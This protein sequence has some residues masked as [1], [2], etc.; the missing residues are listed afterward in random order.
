MMNGLKVSF[1]YEWSHCSESLHLVKCMN[2]FM[3]EHCLQSVQIGGVCDVL[4]PWLICLIG[5]ELVI[6]NMSMCFQSCP[7]HTLVGRD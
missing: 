6:I 2:L 1:H 3:K 4:V 7:H 5:I